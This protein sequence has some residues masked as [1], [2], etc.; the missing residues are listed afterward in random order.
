MMPGQGYVEAPADPRPPVG[1]GMLGHGFM[2]KAHAN[3]LRTI[4]YVDWPGVARP[5]LVAIAG[6]DE[7]RVRAAATRYGFA[8]YYTDWRGLVADERVQVFDN[9][10]GDDA[11]VEPTL[12]AIAAGK[13][14]VCEKPLAVT[15]A[16]A[17]RLWEAA[18]RAGVKHLCCFNYR[19]VPA[20]RLARDML[21]RGELGEVYQARFRYAQEWRRDP[22]APLPSPAGALRIIGCHAIDQ[23]RFLVGEIANV[24]A[25]FTNP[26]TTSERRHAGAPVEQDDTV[27]ALVGFANGVAG[28]IDASLVSRGRRNMLAWE[29]NCARGTL[30]WDLEDL[31]RLKVYA[32]RDSGNTVDGLLDVIVCEPD[33]PFMGLW[34]PTGHIVGWEHAHIN[35]L[36]HVLRCV[37]ED[38]PVGPDGA[39]FEDGYRAAVIAEAMHRS[40]ENGRR[41]EVETGG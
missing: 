28:T 38:R 11:H 7:E 19:F 26:V 8:G 39:T 14:V 32:A 34:W 2:G 6:R 21:R 27:A 30:A 40:A 10:A 24:S 15:S 1:I 9:V 29:I 12:A 3:A 22:A 37:A 25:L 36:D 23:A 16:D 5:E 13:H 31:N 20:V 18:E 33:H 4:P 41:V 17:R 35:M